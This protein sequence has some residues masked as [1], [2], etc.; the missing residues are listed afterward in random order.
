MA[1]L[2]IVT[3][4]R[5]ILSSRYDTCRNNDKKAKEKLISDYERCNFPKNSENK[6]WEKILR[7]AETHVPI[8]FLP[9][10][11]NDERNVVLISL[12]HP[13]VKQAA[14]MLSVSENTVTFFKAV[15]NTVEKG[16]YP[17]IMYQW[18]YSGD[19]EDVALKPLSSNT[20]L[21]KH[22]LDILKKSEC[23]DKT[24]DVEE[25]M[26]D[27]IESIH[28]N[29]W[30]CELQM[31]RINSSELITYKLGTLTTGHQSRISFIR[32]MIRKSGNPKIRM[33]REAELRNANTDFEQRKRKL[34]QTMDK[35]DIVASKLAYG[36]LIVENE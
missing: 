24:I 12:A 36:V 3:D 20:E 33:M 15:D 14:M 2:E 18:M 25:M 10:A 5:I 21:N 31:H 27:N 26:W 22:L 35:V 11:A 32:E 34:E 13:F 6:A 29:L 23:C 19:H 16:I 9:E 30:D 17:F 8:T 28:H 1:V 4:K 7:S